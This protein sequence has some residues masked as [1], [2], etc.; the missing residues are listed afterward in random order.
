MALEGEDLKQL[1]KD[2]DGLRLLVIDEVSMVSRTMLA[3]SPCS[4]CTAGNPSLHGYLALWST[5][6]AAS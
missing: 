5:I 4:D 6:V 3:D 2:L 1:D